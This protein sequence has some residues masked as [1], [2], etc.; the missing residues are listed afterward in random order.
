MA[1]HTIIG[2]LRLSRATRPLLALCIWL[3]FFSGAA[4]SG[5]DAQVRQ[6]I[7]GY[8]KLPIPQ[9]SYDYQAY[10]SS[11]PN[12][13]ALRQQEDFFLSQK[14]ALASVDAARLSKEERVTYDHLGYEISNN[15]ERIK[16]ERGWV[17]AGRD[18]PVGGVATLS[19]HEAWYRLFAKRFTSLDITADE[20]EAL[21]RREVA[22]VKEAI[23]AIRGG[24]GIADSQSFYT[25]LA[26][27]SFLI[28]DKTLLVQAFSR[29]DSIVRSNLPAFIGNAAM[30]P[31]FAME[32]ADATAHTPPGMYLNRSN[33][34]YGKDV[35]LYN[36][37]GGRFNTR[38]LEWIYMHEAIPGHHLQFTLRKQTALQELFLYPG[39]F[40]G[41]ACYV[42]Y[43]GKDLGLYTD[44]YGE[45]GKWEWDL[46]RS[47]RLV[48]DA[49]IHKRGWSHE[50]AIAYWKA[51]INGQDDIAEREVTR[52]TAWPGQALS[53]KVGADCLMSLR[54]GWLK[55]HPGKLI[56]AFHRW[57]MGMGNCPLSVL[58]SNIST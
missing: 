16:L 53:Y 8:Q 54:Q 48:L 10:F 35:F 49:G 18:I 55:Q 3:F 28:R 47:A 1:A 29:V 17:A 32:W 14:K 13:A 31:V 39:N 19:N 42:E 5:I 40:E 30:P 21:G 36:F 20:V 37:Y 4:P 12:E 57:F 51:T 11:I 50:Q 58:R 33:N 23:T 15:L 9:F 46:V 25:R 44:P 56:A 26:D 2:F 24:L 7:E 43:F 22:R 41:W 6:F 45:L 34:A 38:A 52:V 27:P